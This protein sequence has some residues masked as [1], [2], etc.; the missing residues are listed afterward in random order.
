MDPDCHR[1]V[2]LHFALQG[3]DG[4]AVQTVTDRAVHLTCDVMLGL[5]CVFH[6]C[7]VNTINTDHPVAGFNHVS[8]FW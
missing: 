2:Y 5:L 4:I 6:G 1:N 8:V 7:V 3:D